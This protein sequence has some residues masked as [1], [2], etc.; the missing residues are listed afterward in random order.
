MKKIILMSSF[1][2]AVNVK[3]HSQIISIQDFKTG[4]PI[5][6]ATI[7]SEFPK[8]FKI[9]NKKGE[10]DISSFYGSEKIEIRLLGYVTQTKSYADIKNAN[11]IIQLS[12][13]NIN[14]EQIVI[15]S[16]K[17]RQSSNNIPSK[18]TIVNSKEIAFQNPQTAADL[19]YVSGKVYIQKSQQG[20]GSPMIRGFSTNRLLYTV[21]GVRMNTAIF[22]GGNI[23]NVINLDPFSVEKTEVLFGPGSV[24]Y[25]SDAI[26]GV[27]SFQTL[28]P[29]LSLNKDLLISGKAVTRH[30]S[31]N[32]EKT[33]HL[34]FNVG[35]EKWAFVTSISSW[36][37]DDLKQGSHGPDD[38]LK[39]IYVERQDG[40]DR[41]ITQRD[42]LLQIPS[43]YS[44]INMMQKVRYQPHEDWDL[45]FDFHYSETSP[46]GR[47]DRNTR[48]KN[49][50]LRYAEWSYGA[51]KWM[52]NHF[53]VHHRSHNALYD[54]LTIRLAQQSF[55]ES[56]INRAL[57]KNDRKVNAENV[58]AYSVN[59]DLKKST[60]S[61]STL[62]Y[63]LEYVLN[64]VKSLGV[65]SDITTGEK[66]IGPAR[67][68]DAKWNSI[69]IYVN[70]E[71]KIS[72]QL[73]GVFGLRYNY[74]SINTDFSK[75]LNFYPFPFSEAKLYNGSITGSIGAAYRPDMSW[76]FN[77]NF[78]TAFRS[79]NVDDMG[80][81]F[82]SELGGVTVP[83]PELKPEYAYNFDV[84]IA[85]VINENIKV[86]ATLYYTILSNA[87]VKRDYQLAGKDSIIY[88]GQLSKVQAIQ[89][90]AVAKTYGIQAGLEVQLPSGFNFSTDINY[91]H[92]EEE[93]DDGSSSP[94]RH[95][96]PLF[97]VSR[98]NFKYDKLHLQF[99]VNYM[100]QRKFEDLPF[101]E[102]T[103][104]EAYAKDSN[105]N[106]YAPSW[107]TLNFKA[108]YDVS[109]VFTIYSGI[110]NLADKR[111]R[112]YSSGI[113]APGRNF[114]IS[115]R[116]NI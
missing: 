19:L 80:K 35:W 2:I 99:Y 107:Y 109:E 71:Y 75:N 60:S 96:P 88:G 57:N 89:N 17:W 108:S 73:T 12:E 1:L 3:C 48:Y 32:K 26:G 45:Q 33:A 11:F 97:G 46:Y 70:D 85:K 51:Q 114:I 54:E 113:S 101:G 6:M 81:V 64:D 59:I 43:A 7:N 66:N 67:Y 30:S 116:A 15:S 87:L 86:D 20:G 77:A 91:Q 39:P 9:T 105:G 16:T 14:L 23:Q 79:P 74:I 58:E 110:E 56:R 34:N 31:A 83:N 53:S 93:L 102:K 98:M 61:K 52:M 111:Y 55:E 94:S 106:N 50:T 22:R 27:M 44:Q 76:V 41:I 62:F 104:V 90:A 84:G 28:I 69:A 36:D 10:A 78:G 5:Q 68:P 115:L 112:P 72:D 4:D 24:V 49:G 21:D 38:Y 92:G 42:P 47:Y 103:K 100:A 18:I 95:V 82:D 13:T 29:E 40:S 65:I 8:V 25:G 37:F 63:G